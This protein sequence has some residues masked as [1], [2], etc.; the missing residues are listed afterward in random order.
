MNIIEK[1]QISQKVLQGLFLKK[2]MPLLVE[3]NITYKC[4]LHCEY[5][6]V[7][8]IQMEELETERIFQ[9][10]DE[11]AALGAKFINFSGGEPLLRDD[12]GRI[13]D[14][15]YLKKLIVSIKSNGVL[16]K[17]QINKIKKADEIQFSLD[18]PKEINDALRG[19]NSHD[20]VMEAISICKSKKMK[21]TLSS[22][23]SRKNL[24]H[25]S[26]VLDM[27][28]ENRIGVY[29]Q[30]M[31]Q[32]LSTNCDKNLKELYCLDNNEYKRAI[33]GLI[34][35]K[36]EGFP[37][38]N[39]SIDGLKHLYHWPDNRKI[40]CLARLLLCN[41]QPDGKIFICDMFPEYQNYLEEVT[42]SLQDSFKR[43]AL[44]YRCRQ[45]WSG[46]MVEFNLL[47]RLNMVTL[48]KMWERI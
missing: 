7:K 39:N 6:G 25:L 24:N 19:P 14:Y 38:I 34:Q 27:A 47:G 35:K 36:E 40:S 48:F 17:K 9:M 30:P 41:I 18:G 16:V 23:I 37:F 10:I 4:N 8:N 21:I 29:F 43:L 12:L 22:V 11:L 26:Y 32:S 45:C 5:C 2:R 1:L 31:D 3:W 20:K 15:C 33:S 42:G 46:G 13:I 28:K 44:P